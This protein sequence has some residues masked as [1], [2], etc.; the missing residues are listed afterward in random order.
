MSEL[1]L[2]DMLNYD[3]CRVNVFTQLYENG[4]PKGGVTYTLVF[5]SDVLMYFEDKLIDCVKKVLR[6]MSN[7]FYGVEYLSHEVEFSEPTDITKR[8]MS[9]WEEVNKKEEVS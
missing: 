7:E 5:D 2:T 6:D 8:V 4:R 1:N 9:V 3:E